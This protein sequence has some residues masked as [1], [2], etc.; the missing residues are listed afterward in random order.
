MKYYAV[1]GTLAVCGGKEGFM[2]LDKNSINMLLSLD[3]ARLSVVIRQ[4][5]S[6]A[7]I[8]PGSINLGPNELNS[9]RQALSM[10]TDGDLSR[11]AELIK[12]FK[13][14]KRG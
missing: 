3:D 11:A 12:N 8:S 7:G 2:N 14:G 9:I 1:F 6:S 13:N 10:A 4:L 5:A